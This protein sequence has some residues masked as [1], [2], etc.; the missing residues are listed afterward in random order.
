[1]PL[2]SG[3]VVRIVIDDA[4]RTGEAPNAIASDGMS[5]FMTELEPMMTLSPMVTPGSF[6]FGK[7]RYADCSNGST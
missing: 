7:I 6:R 1:M 2:C 3:H 5:L 4:M